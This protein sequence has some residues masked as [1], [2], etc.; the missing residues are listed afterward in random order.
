VEVV[1]ASRSPKQL[2]IDIA[3]EIANRSDH[4]VSPWGYFQFLRDANSPSQEAAQTSSFA[5]VTTFTGPALYTEES[6]FTKIDF[7]DVEKGKPIPVIKAKDG[8][9]GIVQHYFVS[10]WLPKPG[11]E[12]EF[13]SEKVDSLYRTGLKVPAGTIAPGSAE[14]LA[15]QA[16]I[17]PQET[18]RLEKAAA[19]SS[20]SI[21]AGS[22]SSRFRSSSSSSGSTR[23]SATGVGRSSSS[24]SSSSL[25][26]IR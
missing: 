7:K 17:G 8:W 18:E 4:P 3:Y 21:T 5:G 6:K 2:R 13:Y 22:R 11:A 23:S 15:V 16:Y 26:S 19:S 12:R 1:S 25:S 14:T 24:R 10:A 9:I 20:W